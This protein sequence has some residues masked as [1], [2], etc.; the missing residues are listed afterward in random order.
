MQLRKIFLLLSL[1]LFIG[2]LEAQVVH[3]FSGKYLNANKLI[4]HNIGDDEDT[5][6]DVMYQYLVPQY[7]EKMDLDRA[8]VI[9]VYFGEIFHDDRTKE[10]LDWIKQQLLDD[11]RAEE[12]FRSEVIAVAPHGSNIKNSRQA[13]NFIRGIQIPEMKVSFDE[14][15]SDITFQQKDDDIFQSSVIEFRE[16]ENGAARSPAARANPRMFWT[17]IRTTTG[18]GGTIASLYFAQDLSPEVAIAVGIWPGIAS[19]ALTYFS[20]DYGAWLANGKWSKWLVE[21]KNKF[22]ENIRRTLKIDESSLAKLG[23]SRMKS[24]LSKLHSAEEYL[25]WYVTE[26][27]FTAGA[28]KI[29]Q[30]IGGIGAASTLVGSVSDVMIGSSMGMLAQGPGDIA[31]QLRKYQKVS[32]LKEA[33]IAGKIKVDNQATLMHEIEEILAKTKSISSNSHQ[34]LRRIENWARSRATMLSF[35]SVVGVGMEIAGIP[36]SRPLLLTIGTG[37]AFYYAHVQGAFTEKTKFGTA[38]QR[39]LRP[40]KEGTEKIKTVVARTCSQIYRKRAN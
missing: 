36:L 10:R 2:Q 16:E 18:A 32:E 15:P 7:E 5:P 33:L 27:A 34:S 6:I 17:L 9:E 35:F 8:P 23:Q 31:I 14:I 4:D 3:D 21:S 25:K 19:G 13:Q 39:L 38:L 12:K 40:F 20:G 1:F 24:V 22:S 28:I 29:P 26:V 37:G 11:Y 30:A